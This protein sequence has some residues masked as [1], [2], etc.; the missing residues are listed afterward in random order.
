MPF[1]E[2]G[3]NLFSKGIH[4]L[5]VDSQK[6]LNMFHGDA[7]TGN[8]EIFASATLRCRARYLQEIWY[9]AKAAVALMIREAT[10]LSVLRT[11][12]QLES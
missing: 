3:R 1:S 12:V 2:A 4:I 10:I 5:N 11:R 7:T 9:I 8:P 6:M